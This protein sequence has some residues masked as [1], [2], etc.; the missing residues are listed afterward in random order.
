LVTVARGIGGA[1]LSPRDTLKRASFLP[2]GRLYPHEISER[3]AADN[4]DAAIEFCQAVENAVQRLAEMPG[5][6]ALRDFPNPSLS[7]LRFWPIKGFRSYLIFYRPSLDGIEVVRILHA[8]RNI[9]SIFAQKFRT[10]D[11]SGRR[12]RST[13]ADRLAHGE[14]GLNAPSEPRT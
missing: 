14:G 12:G 5:L 9:D 11:E 8:A 7:S 2:S 3:I 4:L 13:V 6:G 10:G 1:T